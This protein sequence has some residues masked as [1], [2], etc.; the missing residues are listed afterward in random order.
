MTDPLT[1]FMQVPALTTRAFPPPSRYHWLDLAQWTGRDG[2][3]IAY[4]RRRFIPPRER[5]VTNSKGTT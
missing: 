4:V 3:R 5:C 1:A 2:E